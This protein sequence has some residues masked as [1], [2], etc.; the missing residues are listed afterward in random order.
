MNRVEMDTAY[1]WLKDGGSHL[2]GS[3]KDL[4]DLLE[5]QIQAD[6]QS[7]WQSIKM[8]EMVA[9]RLPD[10]TE[11]ADIF[12]ECGYAAYRLGNCEESLRYFRQ[13]VRKYQTAHHQV[14][15]VEWMIGWVEWQLPGNRGPAFVD[16]RSSIDKFEVL[17]K[18]AALG[19]KPVDWYRTRCQDM[20]D[21]L[22][23]LIKEPTGVATTTASTTA[24][25]PA[26]ATNTTTSAAPAASA[27][28]SSSTTPPPQA[29]SSTTT[30]MPTP[31]DYLRVYGVVAAVPAGGWGALGF[32]PKSADDYVEIPY[33]R[34]ENRL[35]TVKNLRSGSH[36]INLFA[37]DQRYLVIKVTGDSMNKAGIDEGDYV[38]L[39]Q[40]DD[41][42]NNDIVA[43]E[44]VDLE[45]DTGSHATLK[46]FV[47]SSGRILLRPE[48]NNPKYK[49]FPMPKIN[50]GAFIRGVAYAVFKPV[51]P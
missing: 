19:A 43:A 50:E 5:T 20:R 9:S 44:I 3:T 13:A 38:L 10:H 30:A 47:R 40:K 37:L 24:S 15:M 32:D 48:S 51:Q 31:Q 18:H 29:G 27:S 1:R 34:I 17:G 8:L 22:D 16:L 11:C 35:H 25:G 33:V 39:C 12:S 26:S 23:A 49:E 14:A 28:S 42:Q 46:R 45:E 2:E 4:L 21:T 41:A 7:A 6:R 36:A